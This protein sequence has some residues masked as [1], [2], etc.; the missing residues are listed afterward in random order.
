MG[1][2]ARLLPRDVRDELRSKFGCHRP[3]IERMVRPIRFGGSIERMVYDEFWGCGRA[4]CGLSCSPATRCG[5]R[6]RGPHSNR[7]RAGKGRRR[8]AAAGEGAISRHA[9]VGV[10]DARAGA[11]PLREGAPERVGLHR[12]APRRAV[13]VVVAEAEHGLAHGPE[14]LEVVPGH[15][16]VAE[17]LLGR[18]E[19]VRVAGGERRRRR[20]RRAG[21][22]GPRGKIG[23]AR[24]RARG[25]RDR[26]ADPRA[27]RRAA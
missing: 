21:A 6:G 16:A 20:V 4:D 17:A 15:A 27:P 22:R 7:Y 1:T 11:R 10:A 8:K 9:D 25:L 3:N 13:D 14:Q 18:R 5:F 2:P 12:E 24:R 26:R 23:R 19:R